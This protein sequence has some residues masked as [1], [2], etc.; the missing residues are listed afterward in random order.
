[1]LW[2]AKNEKKKKYDE[3]SFYPSQILVFVQMKTFKF[4]RWLT[5]ELVVVLG[6]VLVVVV[7]VR[8][9]L[10]AASEGARFG[11]NIWK[12]NQWKNILN[13]KKYIFLWIEWI[14][15]FR[16]NTTTDTI[17]ATSSQAKFKW[18]AY[19]ISKYAQRKYYVFLS[20]LLEQ[21]ENFSSFYAV[22]NKL[23]IM[24]CA[25]QVNELV[26]YCLHTR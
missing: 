14:Q 10:V 13:K 7:V 17:Q 4:I 19:G 8:S 20:I 26:F 11:T 25:F 12:I 16:M 6:T 3:C 9:V 22:G 15:N 2:M 5:V 23:I 1:M 21:S 18:T 24:F